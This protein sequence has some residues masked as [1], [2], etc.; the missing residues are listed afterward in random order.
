MNDTTTKTETIKLSCYLDKE[1]Y[2]DFKNK[3]TG[4]GLSVSAY[5]R[6]LIKKELK[7]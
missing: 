2:E 6:F 7:K 1:S 3:A 4:K 5:L